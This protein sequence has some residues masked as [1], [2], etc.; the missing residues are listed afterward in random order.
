M[1][2]R[3]RREVSATVSLLGVALSLCCQPTRD[4]DATTRGVPP[5][6]PEEVAGSTTSGGG[7]R[8]SSE[9]G[10]Q[11]S[12]GGVASGGGGAAG[13]AVVS[14]GG[15]DNPGSAG[16]D[17]NLGGD[18]A[19]GADGGDDAPLEDLPNEL[20]ESPVQGVLTF[21]QATVA[22]EKVFN[23][24]TPLA[25]HVVTASS[26]AVTTL[27]DRSG[28]NVVQWMGAT[29]KR[30]R[31]AGIIATP[32]PLMTTSLDE[33]SFT[34]RHVRLSSTSEDG[35]WAWTWDFYVTQATLTITKASRAYAFTF[36][37]TPGDSLTSA[38]T[39]VREAGVGQSALSSLLA[40]LIGPAE[41]AYLTDSTYG[42]S[43]FFVQ[44]RDD[45]LV[46]RYD[47]IGGDTATWVFGD[48]KATH[49]QRRFSMGFIGSA[50][51]AT[52]LERVQ[53]VI[54]SIR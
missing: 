44:H 26:G 7:G 50:V 21:S 39:L 24:V 30:K 45:E 36:S 4:L 51:H 52:V 27:E 31:S 48:G 13:S 46:D 6:A 40:D 16:A 29:P 8:G 49:A 18:A 54:D 33:A 1:P 15:S 28:G 11:V 19:A 42:H 3:L 38:D 17:S 53:F 20:P 22:G 12:A 41:W 23:I 47:A 2:N 5:A 37:G 32:Q 10:G 25:T 14:S 35:A 43:L 9:H 34:A